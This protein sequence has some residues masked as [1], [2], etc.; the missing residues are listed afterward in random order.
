VT[1][2]F[3]VMK[4]LTPMALNLTLS[5]KLTLGG[6]E[7]AILASGGPALATL[8]SSSLSALFPFF[9]AGGFLPFL[10]D[11]ADPGTD[12]GAASPHRFFWNLTCA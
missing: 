5:L 10:P 11:A 6:K 12:S 4:S 1:S 7:S 3:L 2:E 9:F 8:S